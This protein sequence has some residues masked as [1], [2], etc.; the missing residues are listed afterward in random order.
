MATLQQQL[1]R[2]EKDAD[3]VTTLRGACKSDGGRLTALGK[4]VLH[5]LV[6][7]NYSQAEIAKLLDV[8][9]SA[10][11]QNASKIKSK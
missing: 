10:V 2:L 11:N 3:L 5:A 6:N 7:N 1:K 4:D 8:T 9:P